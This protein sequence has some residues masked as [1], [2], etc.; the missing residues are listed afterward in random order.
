MKNIKKLKTSYNYL[1]KW[2][3]STGADNR[4]FDSLN[5]LYKMAKRGCNENK[6]IYK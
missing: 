1:L 3:S 2:L 6:T 4:Y 5:L